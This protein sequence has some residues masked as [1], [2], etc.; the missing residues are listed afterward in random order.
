[1][2]YNLELEQRLDTLSPQ[3]GGLFK[4][5]MFGGI[6]YLLRGNMAYGIHKQYLIIRTSPEQAAEL[7]K[8][9]GVKLF[10]ITGRTMKGWVMVSPEGLTDDSELLEL[11][12]LAVDHVKS[13]QAKDAEDIAAFESRVK[14]PLVSYD[15]M[16]KRLKKHRT[17]KN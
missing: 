2:P 5:K 15:E 7:L 4:K 9:D 3:V 6:G 14:E 13:L 8:K 10:N 17:A 1:M 16:V 11:L 12:N